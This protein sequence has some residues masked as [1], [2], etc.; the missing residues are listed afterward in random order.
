MTPAYVN[1]LPATKSSRHN[2]IAF[3]PSSTA[4][5][6]AGVLVISNDRTAQEYALV[7]TETDWTGRAFALVKID[8][9][10]SEPETYAVFCGKSENRCDCR[11]FTRWSNCKHILAVRQLIA[12]GEI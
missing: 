2:R 8:G 7:E 11:G 6:A 5:V 1:K 10:D 3:T 9:G 12:D 4:P